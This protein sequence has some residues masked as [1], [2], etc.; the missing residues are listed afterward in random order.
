MAKVLVTFMTDFIIFVYLYKKINVQLWES[1]F[2]HD[3][4]MA[5]HF[6]NSPLTTLGIYILNPWTKSKTQ[7]PVTY[8]NLKT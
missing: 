3:T 2:K 6:C 8:Y 4:L 5:C 1:A 7:L